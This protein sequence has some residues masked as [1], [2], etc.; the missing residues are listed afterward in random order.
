MK[1]VERNARVD[2]VLGWIQEVIGV[3]FLRKTRVIVRSS[4][5]VDESV[6]R[7]VCG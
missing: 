5:G 4:G 3:E 7:S 1:V 2:W 6:A